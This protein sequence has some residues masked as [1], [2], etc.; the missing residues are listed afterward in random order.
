MTAPQQ[1]KF[2]MTGPVIITANRLSDGSVVHR[3]AKGDWSQDLSCAE[4]LT[5]PEAA[6]RALAAA[7]AQ[8]HIAVGP[9]AA[10]VRQG[11]GIKPGNLRETIRSKGPTFTLPKDRAGAAVREVGRL[12]ARN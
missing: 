5:S 3:T 2:R 4:I 9:Y 8:S 12:Q 7:T 11:A 1:Q 10:P 6:R